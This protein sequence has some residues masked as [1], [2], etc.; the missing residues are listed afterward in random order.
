MPDTEN[1]P[2]KTDEEMIA[3][4][5]AQAAAEPDDGSR[6]DPLALL[7]EEER[8]ALE[9]SDFIDDEAV[10]EA[11][12]AAAVADDAPVPEPETAAAPEVEPEVEPESETA[13]ETAA[14]EPAPRVE[15]PVATI[16]KDAAEAKIAELQSE[17]DAAFQKYEDGEFSADEYRA[18]LSDATSKQNEVR[19]AFAQEQA[20]I[21]FAVQ[22]EAKAWTDAGAAFMAQNPELSD[23]KHLA[24][25]DKVV[26]YVT[27]NSDAGA[28][29]EDQLAQS[30]AMYETVAA[31]QGNPLSKAA[32][33][34]D[35]DPNPAPEPKK[36]EAAKPTLPA[37]GQTLSNIPAAAVS[38]AADGKYA[39]LDG[40]MATGT[41][42]Q[43]EAVI[44]RMDP[45]EAERYA[46]AL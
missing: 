37:P 13:L 24:G 9:E 35:P 11:E 42:D 40:I 30:L 39:A 5:A 21:D 45:E 12:P 44:A 46:S 43:I 14:A 27:A 1:K 4:I 32:P 8:A 28:S 23:V 38:P 3:D 29:F 19:N 34:A 17:Q 16:T 41:P 26:R 10:P 7:T 18:A 20:K 25:F 6:T 15:V 36:A 2:T 22:A 33:K 31:N